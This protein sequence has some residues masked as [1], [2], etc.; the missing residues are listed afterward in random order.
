MKKL[1]FHYDMQIDYSI[2]VARCNYTI[3]CIPKQTVRQ[4]IEETKISMYPD[5]T[6]YYGFDG[7]KNRQIYG[8]NEIPHD[9]FQFQIEGTAVT[10]LAEF[11]EWVDEDL[12]MLFRHPHGL[13]V[14]GEKI[15]AYY[16]QICPNI[17]L[18]NWDKALVLMH[19]LH[20]KFSYAPNTTSVDTSAEE[21]FAQEHGVC[22][23][24]AHI[25]IALLLLAHIPARY[26]TGL[27]IGEGQSHAW[28][29]VLYKDRWYGLDPT[30]DCL[31]GDNYIKIG[32]GRDAKDCMMNRGIMH[33]GGLHT[34]TI[35]ASVEEIIE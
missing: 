17:E 21:A 14:P 31:V 32:V 13:N 7:L 3:K 6:Y 5:T 29:E 4:T 26:V 30:N 25:F 15:K 24:Y 18:S 9:S 16:G 22:Q 33:G 27:V 20:Q 8:V 28:V 1:H 11:E 2:M 19:S 34:Q 23:D 10:G 12:A 35:L